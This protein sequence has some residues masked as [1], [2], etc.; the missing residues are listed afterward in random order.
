MV[1]NSPVSNMMLRKL[2]KCNKCGSI[3]M[4]RIGL[5]LEKEFEFIFDCPKCNHEIRGVLLVED[6]EDIPLK[7]KDTWKMDGV[8]ETEV[9]DYVKCFTFHPDFPSQVSNDVCFPFIH[10]GSRAGDKFELMALRQTW[11]HAISYKKIGELKM[12]Y[13][14]YKLKNDTYFKQGI[15]E[16]SQISTPQE[17]KSVLHKI[18]PTDIPLNY[19]NEKLSALYRALDVVIFPIVICDDYFKWYNFY[20]SYIYNISKDQS[21]EFDQFIK[22]TYNTGYLGDI[23]EKSFNYIFRFLNARKDFSSVIFDWDP[24]KPDADFPINCA[25]SGNIRYE[26]VKSLYVDGFELISDGLSLILSIINIKNRNDYNSFNSHPTRN[27]GKP[28]AKNFKD[29]NKQPNSPKY[30]LLNEDVDFSKWIVPLI[31]SN[32]RNSIG[33]NDVQFDYLTGNLTYKKDNAMKTIT[34]GDFLFCCLRQVVI[35]H[36]INN[37][38]KM[39]YYVV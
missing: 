8:T 19:T 34:Y 36:R 37:L 11:W 23:Q 14:N 17:A 32:L 13:K 3:V 29:F 30:D 6:G 2:W 27:I 21:V 22:Y 39:L 16:F 9:K 4:T 35:I 18:L 15:M 24:E 5:G 31:D 25:V 20:N 1:Q 10:A 33:H 28:F 38:A 12:I 7:P 26:E